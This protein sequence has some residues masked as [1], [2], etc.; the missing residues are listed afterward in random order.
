MAYANCYEVTIAEL[1][2]RL[3]KFTDSGE[4]KD[5]QGKS[6]SF[7]QHANVIGW[8]MIHCKI[9]NFSDWFDG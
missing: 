4:I 5:N 9:P 3:L 7:G 2:F 1:F 8:I 6:S